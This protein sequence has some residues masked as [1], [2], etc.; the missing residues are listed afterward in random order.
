MR[1]TRL[2]AI[3]CVFLAA[4]A[5]ARDDFP[6]PYDSEKDKNAKP[7]PA[8]EAAR[9]FKLPPGFR[10][11]LVASEPEICN[12]IA[13]TWDTRGRLWVAENYTYA[14]RPI[15]YDLNLRDRVL[16]FSKLGG[17]PERKVFID[18]VTRLTG[19]EV[20]LGGVWLMCPPQLLFVPS[21]DLEKADG[22][23]KVMLDGFNPP[24]ENHHNLVN[25]IKWGPDG[26]LYGRCGASAPGMVRTPDAPPSAAVP[27]N[28]GM[29]RYNP[30]TRVFETLTHGTTNPWG[31]DW[32]DKGECFF[33]NTVNGH[34]WHLI[35]GAHL[36]RP[37]TI[38]AS[39]LVYEPLEMHADHWHFDVGKGW[40]DSRKVDKEVDKLG[41]GHAHCGTMIYQGD[42][43]PMEYRN[44]LFTL[45]F[46]GRR[47]NVEKLE[48]AGDGYIAKHEPDVF[49]SADPFFRGMEI[50]QGP[51]GSAYILDWS[52][53][54]ECHESTGVHRSSGR[55]F[56]VSHGEA[57]KEATPELWKL[58]GLDLV[59]MQ[60]SGNEWLARA[61]RRELADRGEPAAEVKQRLTGLLRGKEES[62]RLRALWTL[63]SL[64][65]I[66]FDAI[67]ELQGDDGEA[68]RAWVAKLLVDDRPLDMNTGTP[69]LGPPLNPVLIGILSRMAADPSGL[70]RLAVASALQRLPVEERALPAIGLA[71]NKKDA[72]DPNMPFMV[73]YG[74]MPLVE[75]KP[76]ALLDI[77]QTTT[78]PKLRQW[79]ARAFAER[80]VKRPDMLDGLLIATRSGNKA[81]RRDVLEG[82]ALGFAG[83]RKVSPPKAW[84]DY[85][86]DFIGTDEIL[87]KRLDVLFG[88]GVALAE[89]RKIALDG[90]AELTQ[91]KAALESLIEANPPDLRSVCEQLLKVRF[92]NPVAAR[93]LGRFDDPAV[94]VL[95][96]KE[97][98]SFHL[99]EKPIAMEVMAS[100]PAFASAMLDAMAAGAIPRGDLSAGQARQIRGY[101]KPELTKKLN[102]AW[103]EYRDSPKDKADLMAKL[104]G[105]LTATRVA[106]GNKAAG[107]ALFDKNCSACHR[108]FGSGAEI[109]PDLTGSDRRNIDYLL[110]NIVD[111]SAVVT[112]DFQMTVLRMKDGH[113]LSGIVTSQ[114]DQTVTLQTATVKVTVPKA[115]IDDRQQSTQS[116]MPDGLLQP[117][118]PEQIRDLV[119]YLMAEGQVEAK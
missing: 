19:L 118:T 93:G 48:R 79:I 65:A 89:V 76:E 110:S 33:V 26:W 63:K 81:N 54:G 34:L 3:S 5:F 70:V 112:K 61:A 97:Y 71:G 78:F 47:A 109:G 64:N 91:R 42:Q 11:D 52:D 117:L 49:H 8:S 59:D 111:P 85:A 92:L 28:G 21:K 103:G 105:E 68:M 74:L 4:V 94:G 72:N 24:A 53:T 87:V 22:P 20:G 83:I 25:G 66:D 101:E 116:L 104:K 50:T 40:A 23:P 98:K 90:K 80:A 45:N 14:E 106:E 69:R 56:R 73:W 95:L 88:D 113:S 46:H 75:R 86:A 13:C 6:K 108:M 44:K 62:V 7:M 27:V 43:W 96:T 30:A 55:I 32:N 82:M 58:K 10:V 38:N 67:S 12:P 77:V 107:R 115:E 15:K 1:P 2:L 36:R 16:I 84:K 114:N 9:T 39:P 99:S 37:H 41:G 102:A 60:K 29:W 35:P 17:K 119:A 51:D 57:L 100:R 31:H 18:N